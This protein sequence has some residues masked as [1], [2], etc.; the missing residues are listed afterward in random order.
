MLP[1]IPLGKHRGGG[2]IWAELGNMGRSYA[3]GSVSTRDSR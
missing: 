2:G 3:G 1:Q